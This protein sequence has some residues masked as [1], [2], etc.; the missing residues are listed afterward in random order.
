MTKMPGILFATC[1]LA[2]IS[3]ECGEEKTAANS[4]V[5]FS[6]GKPFSLGKLSGNAMIER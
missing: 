5:R 6:L 3:V 1:Y 2:G 4:W